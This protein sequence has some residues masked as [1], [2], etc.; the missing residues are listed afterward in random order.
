MINL[1]YKK[2]L[3][4]QIFGKWT[5]VRFSH[6]DKYGLSYWE[7]LCGECGRTSVI[8][9]KYLTTGKS[10][11][12]GKCSKNVF[13]DHPDGHMVGITR[14]GQKFILIKKIMIW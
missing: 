8:P 3:S 13:Y 1:G 5:V 10:R 6:N 12:C 14:K 11:S 4:A 7:C 9:R 2:D